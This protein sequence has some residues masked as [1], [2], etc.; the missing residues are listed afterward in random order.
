MA[1]IESKLTAIECTLTPSLLRVEQ[2]L[3]NLEKTTAVV[4]T[5]TERV[6]HAIDSARDVAS[7]FGTAVWPKAAVVASVAGGVL[8][9]V[10]RWRA[11][12]GAHGN[13]KMIAG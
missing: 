7:S 9:A 13:V 12:R 1:L 3:A 5:R 2:V 4:R 8:G 10:R 6:D 11:G